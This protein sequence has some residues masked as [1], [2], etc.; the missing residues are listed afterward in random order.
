MRG[1]RKSEEV[2]LRILRTATPLRV[3]PI[4]SPWAAARGR[5]GDEAAVA[6]DEDDMV[7]TT[8]SVRSTC[9]P[10]TWSPLREVGLERNFHSTV[11]RV[12]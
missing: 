7:F 5:G 6:A 12:V 1:E 9:G 10:A 8:R 2:S 11:R 3:F 4:I